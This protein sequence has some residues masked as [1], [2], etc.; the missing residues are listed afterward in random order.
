MAKVFG[1]TEVEIPDDATINQYS[2]WDS[3]R[4]LELMLALETE[5][6]LRI[7]TDAM[8]QLLSLEA[9]ETYLGGPAMTS[10]DGQGG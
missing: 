2:E 10:P 9:I 7:P 6:R 4:H 3:L 5:F 8:L 1:V